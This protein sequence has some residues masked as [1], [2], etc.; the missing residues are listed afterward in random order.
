LFKAITQNSFLQVKYTD[1]RKGKG[2][3][4]VG[5]DELTV[6]QSHNLGSEARTILML[7]VYKKL[8]SSMEYT[9]Q[10]MIFTKSKNSDDLLFG[11]AVLYTLDVIQKKLENIAKL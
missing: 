8:M 3:I 2:V 5:G 6:A 11:K 4:L 1:A 7:D 10:E 9:A